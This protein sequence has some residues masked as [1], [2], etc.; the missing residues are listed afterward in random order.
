MG[1]VICLN[2]TTYGLAQGMIATVP[3]R[4]IILKFRIKNFYQKYLHF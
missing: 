2:L 1:R 3:Y 4:I